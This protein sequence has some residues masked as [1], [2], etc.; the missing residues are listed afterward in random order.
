MYL[1]FQG[2]NWTRKPGAL[3]AYL[4]AYAKKEER[5]KYLI[6][7]V[8]YFFLFSMISLVFAFFPFSA[9]ELIFALGSLAFV[10]ISGSILL[11]WPNLCSAILEHR[12]IMYKP[13]R[14]L[15]Q[16]AMLISLVV[17]G[18]CVRLIFFNTGL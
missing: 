11:R 15:G 5:P 9:F 12:E 17:F 3:A 4:V 10:Y 6:K 2:I 14:R 18:L 13:V 1:L 8:R 7:L 16:S